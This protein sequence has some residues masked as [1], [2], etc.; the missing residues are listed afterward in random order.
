MGK[1]ANPAG[2][3]GSVLAQLRTVPGRM[4]PALEDAMC[5]G[6]LVASFAGTLA[7][8]WA[9]YAGVQKLLGVPAMC[10]LAWM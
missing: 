8:L 3:L 1:E 4:Q 2:A 6:A 7:E 10:F 5:E 9:W